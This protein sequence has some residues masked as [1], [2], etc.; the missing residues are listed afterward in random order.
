[1]K[2]CTQHINHVYTTYRRT[3]SPPYLSLSFSQPRHLS[4]TPSPP[5]LLGWLG[6]PWRSRTHW[7]W[8]ITTNITRA[9]WEGVT[10]WPP[11]ALSMS[12]SICDRGILE[13][14]SWEVY[15]RVCRQAVL[16]DVLWHHPVGVVDHVLIL[17]GDVTLVCII[18][19]K[20]RRIMVMM[21]HHL[22]SSYVETM[23]LF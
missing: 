17:T 8:D 19:N 23:G 5:S 3:Q 12:K 9:N 21:T 22:W 7:S 11:A 15:W 6:S 13:L 14:L 16:D 18:W 4:L 10:R 2:T 20:S 1:M